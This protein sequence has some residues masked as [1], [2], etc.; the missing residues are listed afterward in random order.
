MLFAD[1]EHVAPR[2][3]PYLADLAKAAK[4]RIDDLHTA[5]VSIAILIQSERGEVGA[6]SKHRRTA[7]TTS[8]IN[9]GNAAEASNKST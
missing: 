8:C 2:I 5:Q 1:D 7:E 6:C 4:L 3:P 9:I